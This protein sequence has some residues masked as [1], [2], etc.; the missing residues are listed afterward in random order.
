MKRLSKPSGNLIQENSN[1]ED[2]SSESII[3]QAILVH[4]GP[5]GSK[6]EFES[7][8]GPIVFDE[9]RI[10]NIV[11]ANNAERE[12]MIS[13]Y[14]GNAP[15]GAFPPILDQ[16]QDSSNDHIRGRLVGEFKFEKRDIPKVGKN[17]P[18]VISEIKFLGEETVKKVKD[19]RIYHLSVGISEES[20][21]LGELS[22]VIEPAAAG[23]MVL[24]KAKSKILKKENSMSKKRLAAHK[25]RMTKLESI[26][27]TL[28]TLAKKSE[29]SK[30]VIQLAKSETEVKSRLYKLMRA[31]KL[32]PAEYKKIDLKR[33]AALPKE[34]MDTV[35]DTYEALEPKVLIGQR[36][37]T[38]AIDFAKIGS[39]L[40]KT[41]FKRLKAEAKADLKKLGAKVKV[42][43]DEKKE[44]ALAE[45]KKMA[46]EKE[47]GAEEK[48]LAFAKAMGDLKSC[49]EKG[50]VEEAKKALAAAESL[51]YDEAKLAAGDSPAYVDGV[52]VEQEQQKSLEDIQKQVD[53]LS[54]NVARVFGMVEELISAEKS[55]GESLEAEE[56]ETADLEEGS[57][58]EEKK[59]LAAEEE[60]KRL[61]EEE[62]NKKSGE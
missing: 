37:S 21:L 20:N 1:G 38:D 56:K 22:T 8:D 28:K 51:G 11:D 48:K 59:K 2:G 32:T 5:N 35:M 7:S 55:E 50:E 6:I 45:E 24:S 34:A 47:E 3:K 12:K 39:D 43:E 13:E 18:C 44:L 54:T 53:D 57:E 23:A 9:E 30:K 27:S 31:G 17:V 49:L 61:E 46:G 10:K 15:D 36:G 16:H 62:K 42:S 19:G 58:D 25:A 60:K 33:L 40:E 26:G 52:A 4:A 29:D 14:G 41:Q